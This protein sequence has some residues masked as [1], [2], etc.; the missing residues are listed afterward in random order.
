M[1]RPLALTLFILIL[2]I[3]KLSEPDKEIEP[4]PEKTYVYIDGDRVIC[5]DGFFD[6]PKDE[7]EEML[8]KA[9]KNLY[10]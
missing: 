2:L 5:R 6:L 3:A 9:H 7:R 8:K 10:N 1:K 4:E